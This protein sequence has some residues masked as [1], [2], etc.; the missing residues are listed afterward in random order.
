MFMQFLQT[1]ASV[2]A[3]QALSIKSECTPDSKAFTRK[4]F[5]IEQIHEHFEIFRISFNFKMTLNLDCMP[6]SE[7]RIAYTFS[8]TSGTA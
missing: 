1:Q 8:R 5:F 3:P 2:P 6:T 4:G 7:V